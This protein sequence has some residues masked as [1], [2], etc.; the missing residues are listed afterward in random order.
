MSLQRLRE[1]QQTTFGGRADWRSLWSQQD[2]EYEESFLADQENK[3][4]CSPI[5]LGMILEFASGASTVPPLGFPHRPQIEF[6]HEANRVFPEANTCL[7]VLCLPV[8]PDYESFT[9]YM[10]DGVLQGPT[11]GVA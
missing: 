10:T 5:T 4:N 7:I 6:L 9:K 2:E 11:F 1:Y 8:H 3:E